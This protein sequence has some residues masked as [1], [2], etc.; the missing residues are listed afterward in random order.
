[1]L[2][3]A[4]RSPRY[5]MP[6][7]A[8]P[9]DSEWA[10][11]LVGLPMAVPEYWW[12]GYTSAKLCL[13]KIV[14]IDTTARKLNCF[15]LVLKDKPGKQYGMRYNVVLFYSDKNGKTTSVDHLPSGV[16]AYPAR[17]PSVTVPCVHNGSHT[18][19]VQRR[20]TVPLPPQGESKADSEES[21]KHDNN[22][23]YVVR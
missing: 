18:P 8:F 17:E 4:A 2:L 14:S 21:S 6:S 1:M 19:I 11:S 20:C 12:P 9:Y 15:T 7:P 10:D 23:K 13:G 3:Q 22:F 5:K 16:P